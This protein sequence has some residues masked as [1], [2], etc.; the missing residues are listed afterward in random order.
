MDKFR[1][2]KKEAEKSSSSDT[3]QSSAKSSSSS[4]VAN[5]TSTSTSDA[6]TSTSTSDAKEPDRKKW[7][8]TMNNQLQSALVTNTN[9]TP[10]QFQHLWT[11]CEA[12]ANDAAPGN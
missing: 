11:E 5:V 7:K 9:I 4:I 12:D 3:N 10:M 6:K 2:A 8:L 1:A